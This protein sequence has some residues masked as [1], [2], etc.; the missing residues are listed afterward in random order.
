MTD[1]IGKVTHF[2]LLEWIKLVCTY[3]SSRTIFVSEGGGR[4]DVRVTSKVELRN[5]VPLFDVTQSNFAL[6]N[7]VSLFGVTQSNVYLRNYIIS[8]QIVI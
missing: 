7:C 2:L 5:Y 3:T 1:N 8:H 4:E 6:S